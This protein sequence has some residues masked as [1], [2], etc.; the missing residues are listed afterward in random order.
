MR[1]EVGCLVAGRDLAVMIVLMLD[2]PLDGQSGR[3]EERRDIKLL[4]LAGFS[5]CC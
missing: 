5:G 4:K 3:G 2:A 1:K